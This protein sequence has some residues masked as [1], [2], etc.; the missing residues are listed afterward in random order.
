MLIRLL[1]TQTQP[2]ERSRL[3]TLKPSKHP[4]EL[5]LVRTTIKKTMEEDREGPR[6]I[7]GEVRRDRTLTPSIERMAGKLGRED[8]LHPSLE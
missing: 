2:I 1:L 8:D 5:P 4:Q 6:N 7:K 3:Q